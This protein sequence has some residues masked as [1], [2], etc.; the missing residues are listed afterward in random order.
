MLWISICER[1]CAGGVGALAELEKENSATILDTFHDEEVR[2]TNIGFEAVAKRHAE[3]A[4]E[5]TC[6]LCN[7]A[8]QLYCA[9]ALMIISNLPMRVARQREHQL[10]EVGALLRELVSRFVAA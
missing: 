1:Y 4:G 8:G 6:T 9:E 2:I 5:C 3:K 7:R 10:D